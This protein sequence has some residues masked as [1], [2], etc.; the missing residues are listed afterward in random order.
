MA[1]FCCRPF[2]YLSV[3]FK[4]GNVKPDCSYILVWCYFY[5]FGYRL[6]VGQLSSLLF[7]PRNYLYLFKWRKVKSQLHSEKSSFRILLFFKFPSAC[8][9]RSGTSNKITWWWWRCDTLLTS[10]LIRF[11]D[12]RCWP[13]AWDDQPQPQ[14]E[15]CILQGRPRC[16][17]EIVTDARRCECPFGSASLH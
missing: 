5:G 13:F 10:V 11:L 6:L 14:W 12:L 2:Q 4:V 16:W 15:Y 3:K 17:E 7:L 1:H 8:H 9:N